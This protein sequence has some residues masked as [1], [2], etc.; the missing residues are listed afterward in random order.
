MG[1]KSKGTGVLVPSLVAI[2]SLP[3]LVLGGFVFGF[4]LNVGLALAMF[5]IGTLWFAVIRMLKG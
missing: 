3:M 5:F 2:G 1:E 4:P